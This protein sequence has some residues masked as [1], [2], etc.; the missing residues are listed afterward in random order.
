MAVQ[1][2][3]V[4]GEFPLVGETGGN[5]LI[6][7]IGHPE[8]GIYCDFVIKKIDGS[9][10]VLW[11]KAPVNTNGYLPIGPEYYG[12]CRYVVTMVDS[13]TTVS[14]I[15]DIRPSI[16]KNSGA[17]VCHHDPANPTYIIYTGG[18]IVDDGGAS[19]GS[20]G[21]SGGGGS[22]SSANG[23]SPETIRR[24]INFEV[25]TGQYEVRVRRVSPDTDSIRTTDSVVWT[26]LRSFQ[27]GRVI[28]EPGM[29]RHELRIRA[30][31][32]LNGS[33]NNYNCIA[34]TICPCYDL[35]TDT[36][37]NKATS[38]PASLYRYVLQGPAN[39]RP[40]TDEQIDLDTLE[41]WHTSCV[42]NGFEFN[43][44]VDY[45]SNV[46][47]ILSMI[48]SAGR[49]APAYIDGKYS[50]VMDRLQTNIA[51]YFTPRNTWDYSYNKIFMDRPHGFR[52]KFW[53]RDQ[54]WREDERIVYDDGYSIDNASKFEELSLPGITSV[55]EAYKHGR[56][57]IATARLRPETHTFNT[58]FEYL[59]CTRGDRVKFTNDVIAIGLGYGRV[60]SYT[61]DAVNVLTVTV[62]EELP[63]EDGKTYQ[64]RVRQ[65]GGTAVLINVVTVIGYHTVFT[66]S[67][68]LP[69]ASAP[70]I[71]A[72]V[73]YGETAEESIDLIVKN[74]VPGS[75]LTAT[76]TCLAYAPEVH[77]A[78]LGVIPDFETHITLP[79]DRYS[80]YKPVMTIR[81]DESVID[82][83][84][85]A[86]TVALRIFVSTV[87]QE[88]PVGMVDKLLVRY[89]LTG[90]NNHWTWASSTSREVFLTKNIIRGRQYDIQ[91]CYYIDE[92]QCFWCDIIKH[93]VVGMSNPPSN[94]SN[95]RASVTSFVG[96][97]LSWSPV[98]D[99]DLKHYEIRYS[100]RMIG[101]AWEQ[102]QFLATIS[103]TSVTLPAALDGSYLIKAV[104]LEN[105]YSTTATL[106]VTTMPSLIKFNFIQ[107]INDGTLWAGVKEGCYT[108]NGQLYLDMAGEWDSITDFDAWVGIDSYGGA[109]AEGYF[110]P[111]EVVNLASVQT[112]RCGM[113]SQW[114]GIDSE[115]LWNDILDFDIQPTFDDL[116]D[117]VG[118]EAQI[119]V[120]DDNITWSD[121]V[122][123][124]AGD[125][126]GQYFKYRLHLTSS[127]ATQ[128]PV[129]DQF[130]VTLDMADRAMRGQGVS[131]AAGGTAITFPQEYMDIPIVRA[132][133]NAASS[134][135]TIKMSAVSVTGF[136]IQILNEGS[137]V[138]RT[139]DWQSV[140]Y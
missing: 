62:D 74:I 80:L 99:L 54:D 129:V 103:G 33:I 27:V 19:G 52:V 113:A 42:R 26:A 31:E 20:S 10:D 45:R 58:D 34:Q 81:S 50:V 37:P 138:A 76:I 65:H 115:A 23:E 5:A 56:Y 114:F 122:A 139:V 14:A 9:L 43:H 66:V 117:G 105:R 92:R 63:M 130:L 40:L 57:H 68:T 95:F 71:D 16:I 4:A 3:I 35:A 25:P 90:T 17:F 24:T 61:D 29:M 83:N 125:Y 96:L 102:S 39:K 123:F 98:T 15:S 38:N 108:T 87:S 75:D 85:A 72:L 11:N 41:A 118:V 70:D 51:Q 119:S 28:S 49:A 109:L 55:T 127:I 36:W 86:G 78:D 133:I 120:S 104:D 18:T 1:Y 77:S 97:I 140:G 93:V 121:W 111:S 22:I 88:I 46:N 67:G 21:G 84:Y 131:I 135:D 13:V 53:N 101:A 134:G 59:T 32:Q 69:L 137:G 7:L 112:V 116:V 8:L 126:T 128:Y 73:M 107:E 91:A 2:D 30:T 60:K 132:T 64:F 79:P 106:L 100:S 47:D 82:R 124:I 44:Y 48:A 12:L 94:V 89:R 136:T 6:F 110:Y